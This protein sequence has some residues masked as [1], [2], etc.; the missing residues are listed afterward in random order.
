MLAVGFVLAYLS[1][2]VIPL[3]RELFCF[4]KKDFEQSTFD[5]WLFAPLFIL[6]SLIPFVGA[7]FLLPLGDDKWLQRLAMISVYLIIIGFI[8]MV[9]TKLLE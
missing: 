9:T 1:M 7:L 5:D 2:Q 6:I 4:D 8:I 3:I